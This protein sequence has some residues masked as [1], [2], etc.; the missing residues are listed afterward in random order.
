MDGAAQRVR[1]QAHGDDTVEDLEPLDE[2]DRDVAQPVRERRG[3]QRHPGALHL[4]RGITGEHLRQVVCLHVRC[5][6]VDDVH[7]LAG[8]LN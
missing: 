3:V 4:D 5:L 8:E 2:R 1:R 7:R 6:A